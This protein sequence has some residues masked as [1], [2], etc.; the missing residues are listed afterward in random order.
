MHHPCARGL[1][2]SYQK[3]GGGCRAH[4]TLG[5]I[6]GGVDKEASLWVEE[7]LVWFRCW[8]LL[9][10]AVDVDWLRGLKTLIAV[11]QSKQN[12]VTACRENSAHTQVSGL[13]WL[14]CCH[15]KHV[16]RDRVQHI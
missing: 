2:F 1:Q 12:L 13:V 6:L 14:S 5:H 9:S 10:A 8:P 11:C 3:G 4:L 15:L 7:E 16:F